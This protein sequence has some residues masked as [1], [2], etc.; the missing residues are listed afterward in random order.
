ES[1]AALAREDWPQLEGWLGLLPASLVY[2]K[3]ALLLADAWV[4]YLRFQ[5]AAIPPLLDS[6]ESLLNE[7]SAELG[8]VDAE[9]LRGSIAGR[10]VAL[11]RLQDRPAE[12]LELAWRAWDRLPPTHPYGLGAVA[13]VIANAS[14]ALDRSDA[15]LTAFEARAAALA[16]SAPQ[17]AVR[18]QTN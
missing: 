9:V 13:F 15:A 11:L 17:A 18:I 8:A 16:G 4:Q 14:A 7:S 2:R 1:V 5:L 12:G 6:A 10:R 3:P